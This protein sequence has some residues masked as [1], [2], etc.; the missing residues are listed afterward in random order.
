M[1]GHHASALAAVILMATSAGAGAAPAASA[2][3]KPLV[4]WTAPVWPSMQVGD[5]A[6]HPISRGSDGAQQAGDTGIRYETR[7]ISGWT[8]HVN[9]ALLAT[10]AEATDL[11]LKLLAGQLERIVRVVPRAA[12]AELRVVPLWMSPEYPGRPPTAEYH[13]DVRWLRENGRDPAMARGVEF[14]NIRIFQSECRRMPVFVLHELAHAYHDRVLGYDHAGIKVAYEKARASGTYD[15][16]KRRDAEG[17]ETIDQAYAM[18]N[19]QEYF[20]ETT[21]AFFGTN[22]FFPFNRTEL[23]RHDPGMFA[24]LKRVWNPTRR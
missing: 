13:P 14:T 2:E 7:D 20:A 5:D 23:R 9:R 16:V 8:V 4:G 1:R 15:H 22:D 24:L 3:N 10:N 21:E 18:S 6:L 19:P 17:R 11:A 12:V